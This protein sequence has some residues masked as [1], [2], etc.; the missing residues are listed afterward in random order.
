MAPPV[1]ML[2]RFRPVPRQNAKK[3]R[4]NMMPG[5]RNFRMSLS[6][7][8]KMMPTIRGTT[9]A[10][11]DFQSKLVT[12]ARPSPSR[13]RKG[14]SLIPS[15][16]WA[17]RSFSSPKFVIRPRYIPPLLLVTAARSIRGVIP[18]TPAG[19]QIMLAM[20]V[21]TK[22]ARN[23]AISNTAPRLRGSPTRVTVI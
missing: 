8:P 6:R 11:K 21:G 4:V 15:R 18:S 5:C 1:T 23:L 20:T 13:V 14:P 3:G 16:D 9:E 22:P 10:S 7:F 12:P 17:P 19:P 2:R